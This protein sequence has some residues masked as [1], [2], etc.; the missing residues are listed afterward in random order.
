MADDVHASMNAM[1]IAGPHEAPDNH[2]AQTLVDQLAMRDDTLLRVRK[3]GHEAL[4]RLA[5]NLKVTRPRARRAIVTFGFAA[6]LN[7]ARG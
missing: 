2:R 6:N 3:P 1:K 5:P 4:G 7:V